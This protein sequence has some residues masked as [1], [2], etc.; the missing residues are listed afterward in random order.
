MLVLQYIFGAVVIQLVPFRKS[1]HIEFD[2]VFTESARPK[3]WKQHIRRGKIPGI[4][5]SK[6]YVQAALV[7]SL[8]FVVVRDC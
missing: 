5:H 2:S 3:S 1:I 8:A 7:G 4:G 6:A